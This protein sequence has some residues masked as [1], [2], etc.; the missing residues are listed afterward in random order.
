MSSESIP[1]IPERPSRTK[2]VELSP[3]PGTEAG[4]AKASSEPSTLVEKPTV[5]RQRPMLKAKTM[6]SFESGAASVGLPQVPLQRPIRRSTTEELNNVMDNTSKELEEIENL[7]SKHS[8]R[9]TCKKKISTASRDGEVISISHNEQ[10]TPLSM[11]ES[12]TP[13][14]LLPE[15]NRHTEDEDNDETS[16]SS[17]LVNLSNDEISKASG[18]GVCPGKEGVNAVLD[19]KVEDKGIL[20]NDTT[21]EGIIQPVDVN[22]N[23]ED[24][25][26]CAQAWTENADSGVKAAKI[27]KLAESSFEELQKH[28]E[29]QEK[30][31]F[32]NPTEEES[33]TSLNDKAG[34]E[35]SA[36]E[37]PQ[38]A[39]SSTSIVAVP[40]NGIKIPSKSKSE[41]GN[42]IPMVPQSRPRRNLEASVKKEGSPNVENKPILEEQDPIEVDAE[43]KHK[44]PVLPVERPKKHAPPPVP[45]KPSSRIAAFQ[46]MLQKRQQQDLHNNGTSPATT[47]SENMMKK[48]TESPTAANTTK[49][50]FTNKLNGLFA[51]PGL[52]SPGQLPASLGKK[53]S[54]PDADSPGEKEEQSQTKNVSLSTNRRARGPRGRKLP[55]KVAG[56][57][58]I[59]EDSNS[60]EIEIFNN[61]NVYSFPSKE[62]GL[63]HITSNKQPTIL[64]NEHSEDALSE[65]VRDIRKGQL[66]QPSNETSDAVSTI[67]LEEKREN[68]AN[69]ESVPL[70]PTVRNSETVSEKSLS[71]SEAIANR[72]QDD[73]TEIEEQRMEN[74]MEAELGRQLSGSYEDVDSAV[75]SAEASYSPR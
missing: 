49:A 13:H 9:S 39:I 36:E 29:E 14:P 22:K 56:V 63:E 41:Q 26:S 7:I 1:K 73:L 45:K 66:K 33:T 55:S 25:K 38:P 4:N 21:P 6:T 12:F 68:T 43:E 47:N 35:N 69:A 10:G 52:I 62:V 67:A 2:T 70:S 65:E 72:D 48:A 24:D 44:S 64:S 37:N 58:K 30:K 74:E 15:G 59:E 18:S 46:E 50:D 3:S 11:K 34:I 60:N 42:N 53:L 75:N 5:P 61:W 54:L 28:Q 31:I 23:V 51:L 32:Q 8:A 17:S 16:L 20:E 19:H 40:A 71:L 57:E 27:T